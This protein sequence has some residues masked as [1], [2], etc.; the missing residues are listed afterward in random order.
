MKQGCQS[1]DVFHVG[2]HVRIQD[3]V[4]KCWI[5][6][7]TIIE[8]RQGDDGSNTSFFIETE[9]GRTLLRHKN[10]VRPDIKS[11][12]RSSDTIIQFAEKPDVSEFIPE[13]EMRITHS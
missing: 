9:T 5:Q 11:S 12:D 6:K 1:S 3:H 10:H 8:A 7:G 4:S 2:D 13:I